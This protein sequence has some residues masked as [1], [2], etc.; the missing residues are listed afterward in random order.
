MTWNIDNLF[1]DIL[2]EKFSKGSKL[3][4]KMI[5]LYQRDNLEAECTGSEK[6]EFSM[7]VGNEWAKKIG[8]MY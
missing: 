5:N 6:R 2:D 3:E 1:Q 7:V 4:K 8:K